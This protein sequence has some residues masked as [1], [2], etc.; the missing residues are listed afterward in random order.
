LFEALPDDL[1]AAFVVIV[2]LDPGRQSELAEILSRRTSMPVNQVLENL[3]LKPSCVYVIPPNRRLLISDHEIATA[4]FD[5]P[6]GQRLPIDLFFRSMAEQ[7]GDGVAIVL[8][9]SGADG[10]V[11]VKAVK[12]AGGVVLVQ[13]PKEAT[14][15]SM[16]ASAIASGV[17]D[18]VLP[19]NGIAERLIDLLRSKEQL[20]SPEAGLDDEQTL[21]RILVQLRARTGHDFS[22]YKRST[23]IRRLARRMQICKTDRLQEYL[24]YLHENAEEVQALFADLLI[25][26]TAFFRD[27]GAF[28]A[29]AADVIPK[30]FDGRSEDENIRVWVPGCATGEEAYSIAMLLLEESARRD[31]LPGIQVFASDLD[32]G[33][34][35]TAREGRYPRAIE[36]DI[37]E[38]RLRRFFLHDSDHYRVRKDLR[39]IVLFATHSLLKDP[40]FSRL[41]LVSCRNLLIYLERDLQHQACNTLAYA[42]RP[43]GY[44]FLGSSEG[45]ESSVNS[46]RVIDRQARIFQTTERTRARLPEL[47]RLESTHLFAK[48]AAQASRDHGPRDEQL[49]HPQALETLAPPSIL[50][51][52]NNKILNLS[53]SAGRYLLHPGGPLSSDVTELARPEL[54]LDLRTGLRR[55]FEL[56]QA[57]VSLAIPVQFNGAARTVY[58]QI[59]PVPSEATTRR[60]LVLFIE[61]DELDDAARAEGGDAANHDNGTA[62][63]VRQL[64]EELNSM[65]VRLGESRQQYGE[66]IEELRAANEELQSTNEEYR[67][68]AEEL[69]TSK[70]EL[71]STNEELQTVN[72]ELKQKLESVSRAHSDI[73]NLITSSDV[74][75]LFLDRELLI[76]RFTP[77]VSNVFSI[78]RGDE[79]RLITDFTHRLDYGDLASDA[80]SVLDHLT[81]IEHEVRSNN[82]RWYLAR[83]RPYRSTEDK[84][85]GVVITFVDVTERRVAEDALHEQQRRLEDLITALPAAV[86]TTDAQ[87]RIT[88]FNSACIA[89]A[90]R[91]PEIGI[92]AWCI[93][94][95]LCHPDGSP[96]P[97]DESPMAVALKENREVRGIEI[98]VE[99]F[100][101][102][103]VPILTFPTPL[104]DA[105][106]HVIGGVNM[107]IDVSQQQAVQH[108]RILINELNHRVKNT[109][110]IVQ[111][112]ASQSFRGADSI[113]Q[114]RE[115]FDGRLKALSRAHDIL[116]S[117]SWKGASLAHVVTG[118]VAAYCSEND[119]RCVVR[120]PELR[121]SPKAA[122]ALAMVLHELA[123]NA[124]K[125]GALS[126]DTGRI[127]VEWT[128]DLTVKAVPT[129]RLRWS[130]EGGPPVEAPKRRGF[131][132]RL[133]ERGLAQDLGGEARIKFLASG[134]VCTVAVPSESREGELADPNR[135]AGAWETE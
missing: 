67:S 65:G 24:K 134:V 22:G 83:L 9:G 113:V 21:G 107:L 17:A 49:A 31:N 93:G 70:E 87:G 130:E 33:A 39:D 72:S 11:G 44:M 50:V 108:Q 98:L 110:A 13:E 90:G 73:E 94:R 79:G 48:P 88:F 117:E 1:N 103:R 99:R 10:A 32:I 5:E 3:E 119:D 102:T 16:P 96:M 77:Q 57:S 105:E 78:A 101:G 26:V 128:V 37:S 122:V 106:G 81:P 30:L 82:N 62:S 36:A 71:Q 19:V 69:E 6:R 131:G 63:T 133:I 7:R 42:L 18:F 58:L 28:D 14:Y 112:I 129:L 84:I 54:R 97:H 120:G 20:A 34:L 40:P 111:A 41:D 126:N 91:T 38:A 132:S 114:A 12:E 66:A 23:V 8:T 53:E 60:A 4:E 47:A 118:A 76:K 64:R 80:R 56:N 45:I 121:I 92:D 127:T 51:D 100:D 68:T 52:N 135:G 124:V 104:R 2:H 25:S 95:K 29:L 75:T 55:A 123:T 15:S 35:A 46:I 86:Y 74:G 59:R 115:A 109:L 89:L 125:Y 116:T 61:G 27:P 43:G 85:E